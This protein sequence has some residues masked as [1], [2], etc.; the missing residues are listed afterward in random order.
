MKKQGILLIISGP[1]GSGKGTVVEQLCKKENFSLSISAT[2]RAP[3]EYEKD[4]IHYFFHTKEEFLLMQEHKELLEWAEFCGNYYGTPRKYVV[5]QLLQGKNVI[6]EI[7]VQG[8]LQVKKIYP[9]GVLVFLMPPNLEEL[10]KRLT[11]RGTEDKD[12]INR[13]IHRA[14]EEME[15]VEEYDYVVINDTVEEA[16]QDL[17]AIVQAERMKC[18]RNPNIK[19]IFKGEI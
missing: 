18:H 7:E 9:D 19:K 11:N 6:L 1:S 13:R 10:G 17:F 12:T 14:L 15:L 8:A 16:T 5:E 2:T 3:R 4:G